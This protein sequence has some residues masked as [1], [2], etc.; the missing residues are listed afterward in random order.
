MDWDGDVC[1]P[2][3]RRPIGTA[4]YANG[5]F[6]A[7]A[8]ATTLVPLIG[9]V[10]VAPLS[11]VAPQRGRPPGLLKVLGAVWVPGFASALSSIG[12]GAIIAFSSLLSAQRGWGSSLA[13]LQRFCDLPGCGAPGFRS[14]ARQAGRRKDRRDLCVDRSSWLSAP[15]DGAR[16]GLGSDRIRTCRLRL[17]PS[18]SRPRGRGCAARSIPKSRPRNGR[19]HGLSRPGT[20]GWQSWAWSGRK[21]G[22]F[23]LGVFGGRSH[24]TRRGCG[25]HETTP[26]P[27]SGITAMRT[28]GHEVPV[29]ISSPRLASEG[30]G[31]AYDLDAFP[32]R[33]RYRRDTKGGDCLSKRLTL[34]DS[35]AV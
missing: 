27:M 15:L 23:E 4:L 6:S 10:F 32:T 17:F 31:P 21:L 35:R 34:G 3:R 28:S 29:W 12:Y 2:C 24:G 13:S 16:H 33:R 18:L 14:S 26:S 11:G 19:L 5:G 1:R 25:G 8:V 9:I 22:R 20:W 7:V 30:C